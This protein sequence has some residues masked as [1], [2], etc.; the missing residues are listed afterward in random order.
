MSL[1]QEMASQVT[2]VAE[3]MH[4]TNVLPYPLP[5]LHPR[6]MLVSPRGAAGGSK[7]CCPGR[8]P[9][10]KVSCVLPIRAKQ[11]KKGGQGLHIVLAL[12]PQDHGEPSL[13]S[14]WHAVW[15]K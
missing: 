15:Y 10:S 14:V 4:S 1:D 7:T 13:S 3:A 12:E 9:A 8:L 5:L 2:G 11:D 6:R